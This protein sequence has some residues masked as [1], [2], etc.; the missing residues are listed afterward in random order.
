MH[1]TPQASIEPIIDRERVADICARNDIVYLGLFGSFARGEATSRSD[2]DLLVRFSHPKS[3][4]EIV[5]TERELA[6]RLGRRVDLVT[7]DAVSPYLRDRIL[8]EAKGVYELSGRH[9]LPP[10]HP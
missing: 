7:E 4:I 5:R 3:L 2:V 6:E 8:A 10:P 9:D 1:E